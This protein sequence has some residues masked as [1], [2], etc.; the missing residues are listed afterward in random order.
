MRENDTNLASAILTLRRLAND[1]MP[2]SYRHR[3]CTSAGAYHK[4]VYSFTNVLSIY[5]LLRFSDVSDR[6][7]TFKMLSQTFR[8]ESLILVQESKTHDSSIDKLFYGSRFIA[9]EEPADLINKLERAG[10][11]EPDSSDEESEMGYDYED[12]DDQDQ[13]YGEEEEPDPYEYED[14]YEDENQYEQE[15][16]EQDD[17]DAQQFME[18]FLR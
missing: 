1:D 3:H 6:E 11:G 13:F 18:L 14:E 16:Y 8:H 9:C 10:R 12:Q 15:Y 7:S 5:S 2:T 17:E 4:S